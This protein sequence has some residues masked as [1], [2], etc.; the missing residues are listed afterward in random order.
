M[1]ILVVMLLLCVSCESIKYVPVETTRTR[2]EYKD[3]LK[4]DSVHIRDS[5]FVMIQGDTVYR[6]R[7]RTEWREV[8]LRDTVHVIQQDTIRSLTPL[9]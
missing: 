8:R 5:V 7:W 4:T 3:R 6:D 2:T 1:R 9:K